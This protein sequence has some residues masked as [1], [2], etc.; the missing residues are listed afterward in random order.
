MEERDVRDETAGREV[1]V[2]ACSASVRDR[3]AHL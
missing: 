1:A 2:Q 3:V